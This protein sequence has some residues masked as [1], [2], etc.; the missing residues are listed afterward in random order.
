ML[1]ESQELLLF[2]GLTKVFPNLGNSNY[3]GEARTKLAK[4]GSRLSPRVLRDSRVTPCLFDGGS[5]FGRVGSPTGRGCCN[6]S[7]PL[8][9][10]QLLF[11]R[12]LVPPV[13]HSQ[14]AY[15]TRGLETIRNFRNS[16]SAAY[17]SRSVRKNGTTNRPSFCCREPPRCWSRGLDTG[18]PHVGTRRDTWGCD[19]VEERGCG[20][21]GSP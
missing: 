8:S 12:T 2:A 11:P 14:R 5:R 17:I 13:L 18:G 9:R 15:R 4:S 3:T 21:R 6:P 7:S 19:R 1:A 20:K 10:L 16:D